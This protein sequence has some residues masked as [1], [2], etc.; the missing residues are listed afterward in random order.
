[1]SASRLFFFYNVLVMY[2]EILVSNIVIR[3]QERLCVGSMPSAA[4]Q[5]L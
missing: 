1:M 4:A 5:S 2:S 3:V